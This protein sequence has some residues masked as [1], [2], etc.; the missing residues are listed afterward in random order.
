VLPELEVYHNLI[1]SIHVVRYI[2]F[3]IVF[4]TALLCAAWTL[5]SRKTPV[6]R[7]SQPI[8]LVVLCVGVLIMASSPIPLSFED[9]GDR[10]SVNDR[11]GALICMSIPMVGMFGLHGS[12]C[13]A[14]LQNHA[15]Q[16]N[17]SFQCA[18]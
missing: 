17:L 9:H 1:G 6:V 8:F 18:L 14:H 7:A 10:D 2:L 4:S 3:G 11:E 12:L 16:S 15:N 5:Q 13:S